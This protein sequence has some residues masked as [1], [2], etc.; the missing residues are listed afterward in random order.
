MVQLVHKVFIFFC[1]PQSGT[2]S[3]EPYV[4]KNFHSS[5]FIMTYHAQIA[6]KNSIG[7]WS[8]ISDTEPIP[9]LA[10]NI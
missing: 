8:Q 9:A 10:F 4:M 6:R 1:F 3:V 7:Y 2:D 5:A